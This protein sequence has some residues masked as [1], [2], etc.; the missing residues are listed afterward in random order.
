MG[1]GDDFEFDPESRMVDKV[2]TSEDHDTELSLRP[3]TL[4]EYIGQEK[5]KEILKIYIEA[6]KL[7]VINGFLH[8][9]RPHRNLLSLTSL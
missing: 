9:F 6:A 4:A 1:F 5:A 3:H 7:R 2:Y 8:F